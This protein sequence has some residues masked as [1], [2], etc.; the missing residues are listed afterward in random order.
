M[1]FFFT[2]RFGRVYNIIMLIL[3]L[4]FV[5]YATARDI[6]RYRQNPQEY[7]EKNIASAKFR[8]F[9]RDKFGVKGGKFVRWTLTGA[10]VVLF[11]W[12]IKYLIV[13]Y[14]I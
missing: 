14:C 10:M 9:L 11:I 12:C 1:F 8:K 7:M 13:T 3:L 2:T 6:S 4:S 5:A